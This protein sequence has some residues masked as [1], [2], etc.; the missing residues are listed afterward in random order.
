MKAKIHV[1]YSPSSFE[2]FSQSV[3]LLASLGFTKGE[4]REER[5]RE[6]DALKVDSPWVEFY[7][8]KSGSKRFKLS[9]SEKGL[10]RDQVAQN[11]LVTLGIISQD[12]EFF[13]ESDREKF[14]EFESDSSEWE[15]ELVQ[16][17]INSP[18]IQAIEKTE[19]G[20]F[21]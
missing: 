15:N 10:S 2:E 19:S 4:E 12:L 13:D 1:S 16:V 9:E 8:F 20:D 14:L 3:H 11:R 7:K 18:P 5:G 17:E 21:F 6:K